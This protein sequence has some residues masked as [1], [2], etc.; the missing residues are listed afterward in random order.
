MSNNNAR[1]LIVDDDPVAQMIVVDQLADSNYTVD[2]CDDGEA[3]LAAMDTQPDVI[4]L[5]IEMPGMDGIEVCRQIRNLGHEHVQVIFVSGHDDLETRLKAYEAGGTDFIVK[6]YSPKELERKVR[7]AI[8]AAQAKQGLAEQVQNAQKTA[9]TAM[10]WMGEMGV[11]LQFMRDSFGCDTLASLAQGVF[12]SLAQYGLQGAVELKALDVVQ[13]HASSGE[14]TP[15]EAS[16]FAHA[17]Q[18]ERIFQFR[19]RMT[20]HY[21]HVTLLVTH[22]PMD[23]PDR[24]GR[25]RDHLALIAEAAEARLLAFESEARRETQGL[26]IASAVANLSGV[27][28]SIDA[29]QRVNERQTRELAYQYLTNI[30]RAFVHLGLLAAQEDELI[31]LAKNTIEGFNELLDVSASLADQLRVVNNSMRDLLVTH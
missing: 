22:L 13:Q 4:L 24:I 3:C 14:C 7:V 9:F 18:M 1:I 23:D 28:D 2:T 21:P 19:D 17:R 30:E 5:D 29:Q 6:P 31:G 16:I 8:A 10:S 20:I 26:R 15:L 12:A 25:L 27:I 11:V